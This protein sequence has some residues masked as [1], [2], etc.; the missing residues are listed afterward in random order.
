MS[1]FLLPLSLSEASGTF[2]G[3]EVQALARAMLGPAPILVILSGCAYLVLRRVRGQA[4]LVDLGVY[5]FASLLTLAFIWP[6]T[7]SVSPSEVQAQAASGESVH[8]AQQLLPGRA[9]LQIPRAEVDLLRAIT[10]LWV[11]V[12]RA[13]NV[14]GD[15]PF[16]EVAPIA[17]MM[18][19][20]LQADAASR[21]REWTSVCVMPA[22]KRLLE[23]STAIGYEDLLPFRGS[24]LY[25]EM[26]ALS[27]RVDGEE[28][29]C[30]AHSS[31]IL[32][33][34]TAEVMGYLSPGGQTMAGVWSQEL[35]VSPEEVVKFLIMREVTRASGPE[36]QPTSLVGLYGGVRAARALTGGLI[37]VLKG[38][39]NVS[40]GDALLGVGRVLS[41][42]A[43][44]ALA[45]LAL[46]VETLVGRALFVTKFS[47]DIAGVLQAAILS[48]FPFVGLVALAPGRQVIVLA[49]YVY[50]L[51]AVY[52]MPLAWSLIDLLSDIALAQARVTGLVTNTAQTL[53]AM[54]SALIIV[55]VGT[56]VALLGLA[57]AI[58]MPLAGG[59]TGVIR[60]VRGF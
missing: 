26:A 46:G 52:S 25:S 27:R 7:S 3:L 17:W 4:T 53:E 23:S 30:G 24:A 12:G 32:S 42:G 29:G 39:G 9:A 21:I 5:L 37:D 28:Q 6:T 56:W 10:S 19:Q 55:T 41:G 48:V 51:I 1:F 18:K 45:D 8:S 49:S 33:R 47:S 36:I 60:S 44:D 15:R 59:A 34:V 13:I 58:L 22:R 54:A 57:F 16:S 38:I 31:A 35:G 43:T 40:A 20:R 14:E 50:L 11:D 2:V